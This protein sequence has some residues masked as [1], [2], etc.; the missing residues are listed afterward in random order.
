M[1]SV[2]LHE[3]LAPGLALVQAAADEEKTPVPNEVRVLQT[4][5]TQQQ[6][7]AAA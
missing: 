7:K 4:A 2:R 5:L 1:N 6:P 3:E